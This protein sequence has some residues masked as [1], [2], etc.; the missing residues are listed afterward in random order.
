M[1]D[2][3]GAGVKRSER[4]LVTK[5]EDAQRAAVRSIDCL[6]VSLWMVARCINMNAE[7]LPL[8]A[9]LNQAE[10]NCSICVLELRFRGVVTVDTFAATCRK[11]IPA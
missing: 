1:S 7:Y 10:R 11:E 6:G 3:R 5:D 8:I 9:V 4:V 2:R